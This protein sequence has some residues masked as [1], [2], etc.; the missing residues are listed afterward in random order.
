MPRHQPKSA[1]GG[2]IVRL[3][4]GTR[5]IPQFGRPLY[6]NPDAIQQLYS[7]AKQRRY[8]PSWD[9]EELDAALVVHLTETI[10]I[11]SGCCHRSLG[12]F[13]AY[14]AGH[15]YGLIRDDAKRR[16]RRGQIPK[17]SLSSRPNEAF[18]SASPTFRLGGESAGHAS[19]TFVY[20]TCP[21]CRHA[22]N[23]RNLRKLGREL[24]EDRPGTFELSRP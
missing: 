4:D 8:S 6:P 10:K 9:G 14:C 5:A 11:T 13:V 12:P 20:F 23:P 24:F 22:F 3:P 18:E 16:H 2:S 7:A 15:E 21:K 1:L 19:R 17:E